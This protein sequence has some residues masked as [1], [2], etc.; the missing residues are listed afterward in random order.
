VSFVPIL[1]LQAGLGERV[2]TIQKRIDDVGVE[3]CAPAGSDD[4]DRVVQ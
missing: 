1:A 2:D 3:M 4:A